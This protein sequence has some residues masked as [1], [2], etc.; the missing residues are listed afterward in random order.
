MSLGVL[1]DRVEREWESRQRIFDLPTARFFDVSSG[2]DLSADFLGHRIATPAG[3]AA[4]PHTQLAQNIVLAWL[5]GGRLFE[6]KTVQVID[7]LVINR[8]CIDM[9]TV[10]YNIEWSQELTVAQS[11]E[12]YVKAWMLLAVLERWEP[13]TPFVGPDPGPF[14]FDLSVG[15]DLDGISTAKVGDFIRGMRDA[16]P[17]IDRL[18][19]EMTGP[20]APYADL[21]IDPCVSDTLTL[22]TFHGCPPEQIELITKHLITEHGLNVIVK[23]NPTLLGHDRVRGIL[24]DTLGYGDLRLRADDFAADLQF[25]RGVELIGELQD[26]AAEHGK[27]FGVKLTNTLIVENHKGFLP[28]PTMYLSGPPLHVLAMTLL[29]ELT[30]A[31]PGRFRL[32]GND[33]PIQVSWSAG[34]DKDN[35]A[36][37]VGLGL[38]PAS[39]CSDLLKPGG[40]GRLAPALKKLGA[41]IAAAGCDSLD[42]FVTSRGEGS[43]DRYVAS[44]HAPDSGARYRA[45]ENVKL[46]RAVDNDLQM[47]GCV[48]CNFCVTVCPNDAFLKLPS[49][50]DGHRWEYVVM[51]ESCNECGN[52]LTFCPENGDPAQI[53]PKLYLHEH[54]FVD[55]QGPAFLIGAGDRPTEV[56]ITRAN[57]EVADQIDVLRSVLDGVDGLPLRP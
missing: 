27:A 55:A 35:L 19:S 16:G 23:L 21:E 32:E 24:H 44:L 34:I 10:G 42:A 52:C 18:R 14:V 56:S 5:G 41:T 46:P 36:D 4:G 53:K 40:Y 20:W 11:L 43:V 15:Y 38:V 13:L 45:D 6:L 7:N 39:I 29:G 9:Q 37:S 17:I 2:P 57:D 3:P 22:S 1:L 54:R 51:A 48:A 50:L 33:G 12:E 31:L 26:F 49:P 25:E 47:W 8:P 28:D 30:R